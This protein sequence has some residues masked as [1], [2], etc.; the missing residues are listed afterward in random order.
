[1]EGRHIYLR[2][3]IPEDDPA[4]RAAEVT[5]ELGIRWRFRGTTPSPEQW[6]HAAWQSIL[7]QFLVVR[8]TDNRP[9]GL[10]MAY[11]ANF[12]DGHAQL[13][14]E[15]LERARR[16]PLL[17]LGAALFVQ[18]VFTCWNFHKLYLELPEYN[19]AQFGS[20][21][22][23]TFKVEGRLREHFYYAGR[24]WDQLVVALY[25][26]VWLSVSPRLLSAEFPGSQGL[27]RLRFASHGSP[28]HG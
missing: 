16:S 18:Y 27:Y 13:A 1:M 5:G 25:R 21:I 3:L 9:V 28:S 17:V 24:R 15:M 4:L 19:L 26:E 12:Q 20:G 23:R 8:R 10:V 14:V 2:P 7:A 22:D 6:S 11:R